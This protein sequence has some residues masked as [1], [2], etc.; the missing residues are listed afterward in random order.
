MTETRP[1]TK[2]E[3]LAAIATSWAALQQATSQCSIEQL[4]QP[5]DDGGWTAKDHLAHLNRWERSMVF[6]LQRQPRH[7]GLGVEEAVYLGGDY[8]A[9]NA[10]IHR[11]IADQS[12]TTVQ[13]NLDATH[14]HLLD[15]IDGMPEAELQQPYAHFLP[16]EPGIDTGDPI[17]WRIAGNSSAHFDEHRVY[18]ERIA[19]S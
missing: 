19:T 9:I 10:A 13:A 16:D 3:L 5:T 12:L 4:T 1:Q 11:Q 6:L 15:M 14:A 2:A 8:D 18:I 7:E 17:L